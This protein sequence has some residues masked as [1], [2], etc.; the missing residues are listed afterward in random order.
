MLK[1]ALAICSLLWFH[2]SFRLL[3]SVKNDIELLI[4]VALYL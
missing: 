3:I 1:I 2:V 4:G